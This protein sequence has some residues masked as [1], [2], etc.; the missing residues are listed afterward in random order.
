MTQVK[1][2]SDQGEVLFAEVDSDGD[3]YVKV[4]DSYII[5]NYLERGDYPGWSVE[6][7]IDLPTKSGAI[8]GKAGWNPYVYAGGEWYE[9]QETG[10]FFPT[11]S[12][13]VVRMIENYNFAILFEGV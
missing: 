9:A 5:A 7:I 12:D 8:V 1:L 4:L 13:D 11:T 2:T 10:D 3:Y 6:K